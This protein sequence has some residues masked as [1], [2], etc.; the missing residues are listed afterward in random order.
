MSISWSRLATTLRQEICHQKLDVDSEK[1]LRTTQQVLELCGNASQN[2]S[3]AARIVTGLARCNLSPTIIAPCCPDYGHF[4][5]V[6][7]FNGLNGG[8]SLLAM[9]QIEFLK[10]LQI[11]LPEMKVQMLYADQEAH[12]PLLCEVSQV[13]TQEFLAL[14]ESSAYQTKL[15]V[16]EYGWQV[17][18]M[19]KIVPQF[20][21]E[22]H[23]YIQFISS[24]QY[25]ER[26]RKE[27]NQ[28]ISMY[29]RL[30]RMEIEEMQQRTI[31]TA[32][33]YMVLGD[34]VRSFDGMISNH[35]TTNLRWYNDAQVAVLHNPT[36]VY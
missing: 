5:G 35:T 1:I 12:D 3:S 17:G 4:N 25:A 31:R 21:A 24:L 16:A 28:R 30:A 32:A 19:S 10:Q 11:V 33:Q 18:F 14:V 26:I 8:I 23:R 9:Q 27:T 7:N 13:S 20:F 22:E 2:R 15:A 34:Y 36:A 29:R 6:Y